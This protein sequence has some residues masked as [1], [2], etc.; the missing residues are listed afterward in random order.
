M[1]HGDR[2]G[3]CH[4]LVAGGVANRNLDFM[5]SGR[6][7]RRFERADHRLPQRTGAELDVWALAGRVGDAD[8]RLSD[9]VDDRCRLGEPSA[10]IIGIDLHVDEVMGRAEWLEPGTLINRKSVRGRNAARS[11]HSTVLCTV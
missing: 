11:G 8:C 7:A 2:G 9:P 4:R 5:L 3:L 1:H 6:D 10:S